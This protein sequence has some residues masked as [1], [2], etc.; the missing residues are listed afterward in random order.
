MAEQ[1]DVV[2]NVEPIVD[3]IEPEFDV[4]SDSVDDIEAPSIRKR[5]RH[6]KTNST[7]KT[8]ALLVVSK[9]T[10]VECEFLDKLWASRHPL[11][12][13]LIRIR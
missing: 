8:C 13:T 9:D 11:F 4:V 10:S 6:I 3:A 12:F 5:P 1:L 7:V 2:S